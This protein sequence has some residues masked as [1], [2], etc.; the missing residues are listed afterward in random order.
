ME[1]AN[2]LCDQIDKNIESY[3]SE[4]IL[5]S[6]SSDCICRICL[7]TGPEPLLAPC[8]CS[9]TG[10]FVHEGC[11]K[12]WVTQKFPQKTNAIC[13]VCRKGFNMKIVMKCKCDIKYAF[14]K[15][16][17]YCC[18]LPILLLILSSMLAIGAIGIY[19][20]MV[21][22]NFQSM[23]P[24]TVI[25]IILSILSLILLIKAALKALINTIVKSWIILPY[26]NPD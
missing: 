1:E 18:S 15:R 21:K 20:M 22:G 14:Q 6:S 23:L 2:I 8:L 24:V 5:L 17:A 13:E 9:G 16:F 25:C 7:D 10:K 4:E 19:N 3:K 26:E 11:L 12:K